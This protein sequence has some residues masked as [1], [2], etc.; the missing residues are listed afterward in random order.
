MKKI[1][2]CVLVCLVIS[3]AQLQAQQVIDSL[4]GPESVLKVGNKL[5]VSNARGGFISELSA[6]GKLIRKKFQKT[7]LNAPKG[8]A[9]IDSTL[10]VTY[11]ELRHG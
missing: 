8:L 3:S 1:V 5:F 2:M 9:A 4:T 10:C 11:I 7:A 6:D